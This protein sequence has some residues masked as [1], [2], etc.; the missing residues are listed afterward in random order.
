MESTDIN[1]KRTELYCLSIYVHG[2]KSS[3]HYI[4]LLSYVCVKTNRVKCQ[5]NMKFALSTDDRKFSIAV[6]TIKHCNDR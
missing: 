3:A 5:S 1:V 2:K 6:Q 4:N